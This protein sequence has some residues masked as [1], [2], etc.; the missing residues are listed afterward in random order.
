MIVKRRQEH[1]AICDGCGEELDPEYE[2]LDVVAAMKREHWVF[3]RPSGM[4]SE[5]F[6]FCPACHE[7]RMS[8]G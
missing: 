8:R 1:I 4:S 5:W 3:V 6:N 7:R 2:Y